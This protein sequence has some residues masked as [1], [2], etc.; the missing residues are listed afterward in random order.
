VGGFVNKFTISKELFVCHL[1]YVYELYI[2][3]TF[4]NQNYMI[5]VDHVLDPGSDQVSDNK[6]GICCF[7]TKH[8]A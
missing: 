4:T 8:T 3:I 7:S 6:I 1:V 2:I 5:A